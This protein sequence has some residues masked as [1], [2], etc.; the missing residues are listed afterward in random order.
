MTGDGREQR[1]DSPV[2]IVVVTRDR[3]DEL[4]RTLARIRDA[5]PVS[6]I[7]VVDNRSSDGTPATVR[8]AD[9]DGVTVLEAPRNL[10]GA[11]RTLGVRHA[12]TPYVAFS[13]DDSWWAPGALDRAAAVFDACPRL[14]LLAAR[15]LVAA[16]ERVDPTCREMQASALPREPDLPGPAVLGFLACG[17]VVRR[18]AYLGAGGFHEV[19]GVGG[20][21][22]LLA[23]DLARAGWGLAYV[24]EVVAYHHPSAVRDPRARRRRHGANR[25][26][27]TWLRR[28]GRV[29]LARTAA[30]VL[31]GRDSRL[32][33]VD[34]LAALPVVLRDRQVIGPSLESRVRLLEASDDR[35]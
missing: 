7:I 12:S 25:V 2:T 9:L 17:A 15:V 27:V 22:E 13:D 31:A 35:R 3:R 4:M 24:D 19:L 11:G 21:E 1:F 30:A 29:V 23:L 34:A 5:S 6:P 20:E 10:G 8:R 33:V 32:A 28:P 26:L 16:D 14:A 18:D